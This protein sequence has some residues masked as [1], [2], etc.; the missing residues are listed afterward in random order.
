MVVD[1]LNGLFKELLGA[2]E[3]LWLEIEFK[4]RNY[5]FIFRR[6]FEEQAASRRALAVDK[7]GA[8][9]E[10]AT[11]FFIDLSRDSIQVGQL[12]LA[13]FISVL[14]LNSKTGCLFG[15]TTWICLAASRKWARSTSANLVF[16]ALPA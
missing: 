15:E 5:L 7:D 9:A 13:A 6:R 2:S 4:L 3:L 10:D 1:P 12:I 8:M 11:A 14:H 16:F